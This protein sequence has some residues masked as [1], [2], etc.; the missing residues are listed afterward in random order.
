MYS[1]DATLNTVPVLVENGK[2]IQVGWRG[3]GCTYSRAGGG[4]IDRT[5]RNQLCEPHDVLGIMG[6]TPSS[7]KAPPERSLIGF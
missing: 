6:T 5:R 1:F 3:H 4:G 2:V 7:H